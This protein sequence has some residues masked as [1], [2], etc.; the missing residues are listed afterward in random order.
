L[1]T[2]ARIA[3]L[4]LFLFGVPAIVTTALLTSSTK[5][6]T[7]DGAQP[8]GSVQGEVRDTAGAALPAIEIEVFSV[9]GEGTP[10]RVAG[11]KSDERGSFEISMP[12]IQGHYELRASGAD[13]QEHRRDL[14]FLDAAGK[15]VTLAPVQIA[16][17]PASRLEIEFVHPNG[18]AAGA[19]SFELSGVETGGFFASFNGRRVQSSGTFEAGKLTILGLPPMQVHLAAWLVSGERVELVLQL[20]AGKNHHRVEL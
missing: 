2:K 14:T 16:L 19:G 8:G 17:L 6:I 15:P 1:G 18:S 13:W 9:V 3:L 10:V 5:D 12:P 4:V 7:A 20:V 11:A